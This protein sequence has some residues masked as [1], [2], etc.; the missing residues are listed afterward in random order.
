MTHGDYRP[1]RNLRATL[2]Y[3]GRAY[4]G[5][6]RQKNGLGVQQVLEEAIA[7]ITGEATTTQGSGRT[8]AGVHALGQ[9]ANFTLR[10]P[11]A[12]SDLFRALNAVL[13]EDVALRDLREVDLFFHARFSA[14]SK[15]YRYS[16]LNS[17][18]RAPLERHRYWQVFAPLDRELMRAG[19]AVLV[20][21]H[22]FSAFCKDAD[23]YDSCVRTLHRLEVLDRGEFID[24]EVAADGFL[25]NM[26]R[27][28]VG[29]LVHV[30]QSRLTPDDLRRALETGDRTAV[31]PT[32]PP[33]GLHLV[34]VSYPA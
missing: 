8:D 18:V 2:E 6:E 15:T 13:P 33:E 5:W 28:L 19:A 14:V 29:S 34:E 21:R 27:I 20:G 17:R 11:I 10:H 31:G 12:V 22:D 16:I 32:V 1:P 25:W 23:S 24:V 3:D 7:R 26:V 4:V 30:G 9:V